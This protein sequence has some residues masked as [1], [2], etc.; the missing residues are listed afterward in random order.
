MTSYLRSP[1]LRSRVKRLTLRGLD[2]VAGRSGSVELSGERLQTHL[3]WRPDPRPGG[4]IVPPSTRVA[5]TGVVPLTS[6][7]FVTG[8]FRAGTT[9]LWNVLRNARGTTAYYEP[10]NERRWFDPAK[11]GSRVDKT[12]RG[13]SSYW[14]EYDGLAD[15]APLFRS[16]WHERNLYMGADASDPA[17][18]AYVRALITHAAA[19]PVLQFNRID[20]R[21]PWFRARFPDAFIVHLL[22]NPRDQWCS[23]LVDPSAFGSEAPTELFERF[24]HFYLRLWVDQLRAPFPCLASSDGAHP[25]RAFYLLWRLSQVFGLSY[26][27]LTITLEDLVG[28]PDEAIQTL[29][30]A[31]GLATSAVESA[32]RVVEPSPF[33]RWMEYASD[34]WFTRHEDAAEQALNGMIA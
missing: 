33:G 8:R 5:D 2:R 27:N 12:H 9:L 24:D 17:M 1:R 4:R 19:R 11:R 29:L 28:Q 20:F 15:L 7:I 21:L 32:V 23:T 3:G 30:A 16:R 18:E 25:Y 6:P 14:D 10:F 13:V 31:T 22:R 34:Q 26:A